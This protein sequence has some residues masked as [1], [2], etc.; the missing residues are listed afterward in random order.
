MQATAS[1][2]KS[3]WPAH[4]R[5]RLSRGSPVSVPTSSSAPFH[6]SP[7][8]TAAARTNP[9]SAASSAEIQMARDSPVPR[10]LL[11]RHFRPRAGS[12]GNWLGQAPGGSGPSHS[13]AECQALPEAVHSSSGWDSCPSVRRVP[14]RV[15][16]G[17]DTCRACVLVL[18]LLRVSVPGG[19]AAAETADRIKFVFELFSVRLR[20]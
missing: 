7:R 3:R 11:A 14:F 9:R 6:S 4:G 8:R 5:P 10:T 19:E 15:G 17:P 2:V 18:R 12:R 13:T 1:M 16:S 20:N